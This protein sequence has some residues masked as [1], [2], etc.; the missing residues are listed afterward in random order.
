[1]SKAAVSDSEL[2][3]RLRLKK[4]T[5]KIFSFSGIHGIPNILEPKFLLFKVMWTICFV[6]AFC[7]CVV[8]IVQSFEAYKCKIFV[9]SK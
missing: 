6:V 3:V 8:L 4:E 7:L 2:S 1:M 5:H 9:S